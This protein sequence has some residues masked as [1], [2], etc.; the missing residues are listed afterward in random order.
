MYPW[1]IWR[2]FDPFISAVINYCGLG[3][4]LFKMFVENIFVENIFVVFTFHKRN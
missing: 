1:I 3:I 2:H 4:F